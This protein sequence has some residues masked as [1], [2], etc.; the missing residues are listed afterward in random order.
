MKS[1]KIKRVTIH[2]IFFFFFSILKRLLELY[3]KD[4]HLLYK[5][6]RNLVFAHLG[7][8]LRQLSL[9]FRH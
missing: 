1:N 7:D 4:L 8:A 5:I 3:I 2:E 9:D 6:E